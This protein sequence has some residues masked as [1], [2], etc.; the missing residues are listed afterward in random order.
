MAIKTTNPE[1]EPSETIDRLNVLSRA[2]VAVTGAR[3]E[4]YG[5]PG[6]N[7]A[8]IASLWQAYIETR[9]V[10]PIA[11][12]GVCVTAED[13]A[14]MMALLKIGRLAT[15]GGS[16]DTWI[17]IAGYAAIGGEIAAKTRNMP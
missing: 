3:E 2:G 1:I 15:G 12:G 9:C 13:V 11:R 10:P 7:L 16:D 5:D 14:A 4:E 17:D 8:C 6:E